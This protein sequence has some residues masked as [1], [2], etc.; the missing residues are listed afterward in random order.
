[1]LQ[2][3]YDGRAITNKRKGEKTMKKL[4]A[5][6]LLC[7]FCTFTA[8]QTQAVEIVKEGNTGRGYVSVSSST[9]DDF[10]PTMAQVNVAVENSSKN[11]AATTE[12]NKKTAQK[13]IDAVK[14]QLDAS[15]GETI[16]TIAFNVNSEYSYKNNVKTFENYKVV[17]SVQ[18]KVKDTAKLGQIIDTALNAGATR[19]DGV[20]FSL[21]STDVA[22][23]QL[24]SQ[25]VSEAKVKS[26]N[27]AKALGMKLGD[28]KQMNVGCFAD[29]GYMPYYRTMDTGAKGTLNSA[30]E[31]SAI[32]T[33]AGT[34][35]VRANV[36]AQF[37]LNK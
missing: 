7:A 16:K 35:K 12:E 23:N 31:S 25:A 11:L 8:I 2:S 34:I 22:C 9:S 33:E 36:D 28:I 10:M 1:V 21:A 19:V 30:P 20:N 4:I 26:E 32:P 3:G 6:S 29:N 14:K 37:F 18:I 24:I 13:V 17:N 15:K 27:V 5:L